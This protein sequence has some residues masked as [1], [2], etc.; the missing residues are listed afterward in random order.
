MTSLRDRKAFALFPELGS[1][2]FVDIW[3]LCVGRSR[4]AH[5][6]GKEREAYAR[7]VEN[8]TVEWYFRYCVVNETNK[9]SVCERTKVK[10]RYTLMKDIIDIFCWVMCYIE[11][12][13]G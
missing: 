5:C 3:S 12:T 4:E 2:A 9:Q 10:K 11:Q 1:F 13:A 6:N 8:G 7:V